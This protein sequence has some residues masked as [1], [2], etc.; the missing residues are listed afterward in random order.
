MT[1][2]AFSAWLT[3][4]ADKSPARWEH[5]SVVGTL[6]ARRRL[7]DPFELFLVPQGRRRASYVVPLSETAPGT[8]DR[9]GG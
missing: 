6:T 7:E 9:A 5:T 8:A 2:V 3:A 4:A 1:G